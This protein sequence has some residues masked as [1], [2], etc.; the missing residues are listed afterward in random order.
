MLNWLYEV[1]DSLHTEQKR[2]KNK[3]IKIFI[4]NEVLEF[5]IISTHSW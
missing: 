5:R 4:M 2:T 1:F 3:P